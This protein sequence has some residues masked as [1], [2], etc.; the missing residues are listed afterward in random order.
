MNV[1]TK[2]RWLNGPQFPRPAALA[3]SEPWS[4]DYWAIGNAE[5]D[6]T[7]T[8]WAT[9][10]MNNLTSAAVEAMLADGEYRDVTEVE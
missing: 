2:V 5:G 3:E 6:G 1:T 7:S 4:P 9:Y 8:G 10:Q